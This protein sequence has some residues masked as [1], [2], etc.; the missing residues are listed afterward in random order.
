MKNNLRSAQIVAGQSQ[1]GGSEVGATQNSRVMVLRLRARTQS[2]SA[3]PR[4]RSHLARHNPDRRSNLMRPCAKAKALTRNPPPK[5][6]ATANLALSGPD[7]SL[8]A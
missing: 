8:A 5:H 1:T 7:I 6:G 4:G 2:P 3:S